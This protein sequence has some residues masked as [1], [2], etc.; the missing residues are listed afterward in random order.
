[1]EKLEPWSWRACSIRVLMMTTEEGFA[2][3]RQRCWNAQGPPQSARSDRT[4]SL[5]V[6]SVILS[7]P[8]AGLGLFPLIAREPRAVPHALGNAFAIMH[9]CGLG[10]ASFLERKGLSPGYLPTVWAPPPQA[11]GL[12]L[13]W[14]PPPHQLPESL[15]ISECLGGNWVPLLPLILPGAK[16]SSVTLVRGAP[17]TEVKSVAVRA[18]M[19]RVGAWV[20]QELLSAILL[21][22]L[23]CYCCLQ[24]HSPQQ[25]HRHH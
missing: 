16:G 10:P 24:H 20:K 19:F 21:Q 12:F 18:A 17:E 23:F 4:W 3:A 13:D 15:H 25:C 22:L 8:S 6:T 5:L 14:E 11:L 2:G 1:M 7:R 9:D